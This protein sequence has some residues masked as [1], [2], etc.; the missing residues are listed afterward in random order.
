[1]R[2]YIFTP[3]HLQQSMIPDSADI[4]APVQ[5]VFSRDRGFF[6]DST[7]FNPSW[8]INSGTIVT[9]IGDVA[10]M[11]RAF[12]SGSLLSKTGLSEILAPTNVGTPPFTVHQGFLFCSRRP[13]RQ[14]V[15]SQSRVG[16]SRVGR[17]GSDV[18]MAYLPE[19]D[20]TIVVSTAFSAASV[21]SAKG[22]GVKFLQ[23]AASYLAPRRP[24]PHLF[25]GL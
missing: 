19:S 6:G 5:H 9:T 15:G 23:D 7:F 20:L 22:P 24:I 8:A 17:P 3:L 10:V 1:M 14:H 21:P 18:I 12:G 13:G 25:T 4:P 2:Q 16:R 11:Q